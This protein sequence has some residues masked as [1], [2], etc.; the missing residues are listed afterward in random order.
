MGAG[1]SSSTS[2][3]W[4]RRGVEVWA[5]KMSRYCVFYKE[6]NCKGETVRW[7][8]GKRVESGGSE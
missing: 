8:D 4:W 3:L 6:E 5:D 7:V 2:H 1:K